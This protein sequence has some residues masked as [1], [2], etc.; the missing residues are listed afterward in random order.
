MLF[1]LTDPIVQIA[2][3]NTRNTLFTRSEKGVLQVRCLDVQDSVSFEQLR[4][5]NNI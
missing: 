2:I 5:I 4:H 1:C 3:D